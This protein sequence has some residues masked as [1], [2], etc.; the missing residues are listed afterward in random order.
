[1]IIIANK[2]TIFMFILIVI[3]A[4]MLLSLIVSK[5]VRSYNKEKFRRLDIGDKKRKD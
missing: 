1:M 5:V 2:S 4:T 3:V